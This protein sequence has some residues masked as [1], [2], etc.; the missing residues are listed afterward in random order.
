MLNEYKKFILEEKFTLEEKFVLNEK[1][2][3][4]KYPNIIKFF[5]EA[6]IKDSS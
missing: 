3:S 5:P 4:T 1:I 2:D 6:A